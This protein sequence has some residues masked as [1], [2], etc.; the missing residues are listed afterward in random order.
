[1]TNTSSGAV[2]IQSFLTAVQQLSEK[3]MQAMNISTVG[4]SWIDMDSFAK[5]NATKLTM[6]LIQEAQKLQQHQSSLCVYLCDIHLGKL[7]FDRF[8]YLLQALQSH[9]F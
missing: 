5:F 6:L 1:M 7:K 3:M 8:K 4:F 9:F 2:N